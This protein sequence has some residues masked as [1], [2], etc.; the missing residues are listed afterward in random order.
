MSIQST[1]QM[2]LSR[3]ATSNDTTPDLPL[4]RAIHSTHTGTSHQIST[5]PTSWP[6][7]RNAS[8]P[9]TLPSPSVRISIASLTPNDVSFS[10]TLSSTRSSP[11]TVNS[12]SNETA[13]NSLLRACDTE[14]HLPQSSTQ[15]N[16][17]T[18][19]HQR[20]TNPP[21]TT[22]GNADSNSEP[23]PRPKGTSLICRPGT[24]LACANNS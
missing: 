20:P 23:W 9:K 12:A 17:P 21:Q 10:R 1:P 2:H 5:S 19:P 11:T 4:H 13:C 22:P 14:Q 18:G 3:P 16:W 7:D 8:S 24:Y 6:G 15:K